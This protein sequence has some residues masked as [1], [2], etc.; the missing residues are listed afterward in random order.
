MPCAAGATGEGRFLDERH[1]DTL[2]FRN[3]D[4]FLS[5]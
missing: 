2:P 5:P 1:L 4:D 3:G